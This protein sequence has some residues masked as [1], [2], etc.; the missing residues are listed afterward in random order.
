LKRAVSSAN[1]GSAGQRQGVAELQTLRPGFRVADESTGQHGEVEFLPA[2]SHDADVLVRF[3]DDPADYSA[4]RWV[5]RKQLQLRDGTCGRSRERADV[6]AYRDTVKAIE[7]SNCGTDS[8]NI[9]VM[10]E[11]PEPWVRQ[12]IAIG[13]IKNVP[14]PKGMEWWDP[15]GFCDVT[16]IRG[17]A[18]ESGLYEEIVQSVEWEQDRVWRVRKE[19]GEDSWHLRTVKECPGKG[20]RGFCGRSLQKVPDNTHQIG[21][22]DRRAA[23]KTKPHSNWACERAGQCCQKRKIEDPGIEPY[24]WCPACRWYACDA[25]VREMPDKS[26]SKQLW[27][28]QPGLSPRFDKLVQDLVKDFCLP[29]P[30]IE[31]YTVK[32]N[33][34]PDGLARVSPHRHDNWTLLLSLGS[35]RVLTVDRANVLM[36]DGD[37]IL[38]GTQSHGVPEMPSCAG[39]RLSLVLMFSPDPLVGAA[40]NA[41]LSAGV[42][43]AR[44]GTKPPSLPT[45]P[46]DVR[47][48]V[49][50]A[51]TLS[52]PNGHSLE[53]YIMPSRS[54]GECNGCG[55]KIRAGDRVMVCRPCNFGLCAGCY[56]KPQEEDD[57]AEDAE[58]AGILANL[59]A[60]GFDH[61]DAK[62]ALKAA[63]GDAEQA[64]SL[65]L[66]AAD[67]DIDAQ[68][69]LS[70]Q[71]G[72]AD[73]IVID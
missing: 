17:Y 31:R 58:S 16:Y 55:R 22:Q 15:K 29:D 61:R 2:A 25:C 67:M 1:E 48:Y 34:Y 65:L 57:Q 53:D 69:Q 51:Q 45:R 46:A 64:A 54:A 63:G 66:A 33:W 40:A 52:C 68:S 43:F 12:K 32:M 38:F 62:N 72:Q 44:R 10:L 73:P 56:G 41:R 49:E 9:A 14:K 5:P 20:H 28:W 70:Q 37:V 4:L 30:W 3:G 60:L 27:H 59:C 50:E 42:A 26:T 71:F 13:S 11:R 21:P 47:G 18:H 24:W 8:A 39:G 36:E 7:L 6:R 19:E 35:P 23:A